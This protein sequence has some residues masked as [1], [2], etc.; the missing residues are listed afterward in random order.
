MEEL[1]VIAAC[2]SNKGCNETS[3]AYYNVNPTVREY[4]ENVETNSK[5][6]I[7]PFVLEY[8][9]PLVLM[10]TGTDISVK[11]NRTFSIK[12]DKETISLIYKEDF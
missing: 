12:K 8:A 1:L 7:N 11:L 2:L 3:K 5:K 10:S 6:L 9:G 4:I